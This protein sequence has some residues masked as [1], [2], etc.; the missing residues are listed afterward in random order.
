MTFQTVSNA[1]LIN[2]ARG[3]VIDQNALIEALR[4]G[5]LAGSCLDVTT[6]EPLTHDSPLWGYG[7]CN[8]NISHFGNTADSIV[9]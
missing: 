9:L 7:K 6:P 8:T 1:Y 5:Q 2:V 4:N 3:E